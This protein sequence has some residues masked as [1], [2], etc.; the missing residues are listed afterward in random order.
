VQ[1]PVSVKRLPQ[2]AKAAY[3]FATGVLWF[4]KTE[5]YGLHAKWRNDEHPGIDSGY[6]QAHALDRH[7]EFCRLRITQKQ[8][9]KSAKFQTSKHKYQSNGQ[10]QASNA[11]NH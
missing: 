9:P 6:H 4:G 10:Q 2:F 5:E 7:R 1:N 8:N 11:A 3:S